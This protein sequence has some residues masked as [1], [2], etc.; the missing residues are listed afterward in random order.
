MLNGVLGVLGYGYHPEQWLLFV[1]EGHANYLYAAVSIVQGNV[2]A[3]TEFDQCVVFQVWLII[4]GGERRL[5]T[6]RAL[7]KSLLVGVLP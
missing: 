4:G 1:C 3:E 6:N 2:I 5:L 7:G